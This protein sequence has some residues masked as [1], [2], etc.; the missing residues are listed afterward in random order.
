MKRPKIK[1]MKSERREKQ[2]RPK[3]QV[4]GKSVFIIQRL[5]HQG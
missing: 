3:M 1:T 4:S 5:R 2:K